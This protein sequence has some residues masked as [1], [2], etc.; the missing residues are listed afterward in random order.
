MSV[1]AF[2]THSSVKVLRAAGLPEAQAEGITAVMRES[3]NVDFGVLATKADLASLATKDD[4]AEGRADFAEAKT[5][6]LKRTVGMIGGAVVINAMTV[7][8]AMLALVRTA[9]H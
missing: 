3:S 6:I 4:L 8:G 9:A 2:D 7:I 5:D 1:P